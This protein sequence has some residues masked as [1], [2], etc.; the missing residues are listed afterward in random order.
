MFDPLAV[1]LLV[2]MVVCAPFSATL[3]FLR[4]VVPARYKRLS[5]IV[6]IA[7]VPFSALMYFCII[8]D[9]LIRYDIPFVVVMGIGIAIGVLRHTLVAHATGTHGQ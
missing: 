8:F 4:M 1:L 9:I 5:S 7:E 2:I 6:T 3:F